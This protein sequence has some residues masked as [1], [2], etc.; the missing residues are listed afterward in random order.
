[1]GTVGTKPAGDPPDLV[2]SYYQ[3]HDPRRT[4]DWPSTNCGVPVFKVSK[5]ESDPQHLHRVTCQSCIAHDHR[6]TPQP[7]PPPPPLTVA[8]N[9]ELKPE[10]LSDVLITAF[11]GNYGGCWYWAKPADSD[12]LKSD[13][14]T[15]LSCWVKEKEPDEDSDIT[16][17]VNHTSVTLGMQRL[18]D[19][20]TSGDS[21]AMWVQA[22]LAQDAG[23]LD[24]DACDVI[25]Q[26]AVFDEVKYG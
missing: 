21:H 7:P 19:R 15:W 12:W 8:V 6:I 24:A 23:D 9:V 22:I 13:D 2:H 26:Y 10:F 1:M 17:L 4:G 11:D 20:A 5:A 18:L 14:G 25:I 3:L 16:Y